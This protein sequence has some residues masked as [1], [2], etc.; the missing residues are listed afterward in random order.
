MIKKI[1]EYDYFVSSDGKVFNSKMKELKP[2]LHT[3][4]YLRVS[5]C[6]NGVVKDF[7]IHRLVAFAFLDKPLDL[8]EINHKDSNK[9]N[10]C[11]DNL[12][13]CNGSHN[14]NHALFA[15]FKTRGDQSKTSK[16][17]ASEVIDIRSSNESQKYLSLKYGVSRAT[18]FNIKKCLKWR[19]LNG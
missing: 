4:G 10:N 12:E 2:R 5:L 7:Y 15:G 19:W 13:W 17:K 14:H 9:K 18:I 1:D 6:K 11:V 8:N 16:L 3:G